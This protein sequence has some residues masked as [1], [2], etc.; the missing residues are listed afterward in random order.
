MNGASS[1]AA[2][3]RM[4]ATNPAETFT[5]VSAATSRAARATGT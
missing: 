1:R 5:P 2:L 3:P 4:P